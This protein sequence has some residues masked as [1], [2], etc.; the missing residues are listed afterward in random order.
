MRVGRQAPGLDGLFGA[1][2]AALML[3]IAITESAAISSR[4]N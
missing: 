2:L 4:T 3:A 1:F